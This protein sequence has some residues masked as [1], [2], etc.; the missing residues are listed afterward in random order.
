MSQQI[1]LFKEAVHLC[2][3][4]ASGTVA[5]GIDGRTVDVPS[6]ERHEALLRLSANAAEMV[7]HS[8]TPAPAAEPE[9]QAEPAPPATP[10]ES[11]T[12]AA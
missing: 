7:V 6:C 3:E 11:A 12:P 10:V 4:P 1:C 8:E 9:H 5:I 2:G